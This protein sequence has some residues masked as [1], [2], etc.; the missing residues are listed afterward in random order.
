MKKELTNDDSKTNID[1]GLQSCQKNTLGSSKVA[2]NEKND[3]PPQNSSQAQEENKENSMVQAPQTQQADKKI[4]VVAVL[5]DDY[6]NLPS[7]DDECFD[8]QPQ[9][10]SQQQQQQQQQP[11]QSQ[12]E[13]PQQKKQEQPSLK[14][15]LLYTSPSPRDGL[16]SRMP[17]SA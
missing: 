5:D 13:Q 4:D 6:D 10:Q 11:Q 1:P 16:L 8:Q 12:Q 9:Q 15:C 2:G 7:S 14:G 17:S 3:V